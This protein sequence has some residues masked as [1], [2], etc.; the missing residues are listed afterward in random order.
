VVQIFLIM[1]LTEINPI[2][3]AQLLMRQFKYAEAHDVLA[4]AFDKN[5]SRAE[6]GR[7]ANLISP[8]GMIPEAIDALNRLEGSIEEYEANKPADEDIGRTV[9]IGETTPATA[10]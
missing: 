10:I 2:K 4:D 6:L 1:P 3:A 9:P 5:P 7:I 8:C